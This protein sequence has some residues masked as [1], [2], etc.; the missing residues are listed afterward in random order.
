ML[1]KLWNEVEKCKQ[2]E[3]KNLHTAQGAKGSVHL[4]HIRGKNFI[5]LVFLVGNKVSQNPLQY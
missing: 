5:W 2:N 3:A 1:G 4:R